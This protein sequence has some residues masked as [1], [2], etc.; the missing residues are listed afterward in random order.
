MDGP[1][2]TAICCAY[3]YARW[4][5]RALDSALAQGVGPETLEVVVVDDGSTDDTAD[6]VRP[7]L[8]SPLI[9]YVWKP[10]GGFAS[11]VSRGFDEAR[12]RYITF[13]DADDEWPLDRLTAQVDVLENSPEIGL[14]YSDMEVIDENSNLI[15]P[16]F[17]QMIQLPTLSGSLLGRL[18]QSNFISG[19]SLMVRAELMSL[20]NPIPSQIRCQDWWI[21]T[22]TASAAEIAWVPGI[23]YRYRQHGQNMNLGQADRSGNARDD[24]EFRRLV[25]DRPE[26]DTVPL[27]ELITASIPLISS[28]IELRSLVSVSAEDRTR[29]A[30]LEQQARAEIFNRRFEAALRTL[31]RAQAANPL[32]ERRG[33]FEELTSLHLLRQEGLGDV[34]TRRVRVLAFASELI[35]DPELLV[36][37]RAAL[38]GNDATVVCQTLSDAELAGIAAL[39]EAAAPD[40]DMVAVTEDVNRLAACCDILLSRLERPGTLRLINRVDSAGALRILVAEQLL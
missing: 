24:F 35:A 27:T 29:S 12:G 8:D 3:N 37:A 38:A 13:L 34:E 22:R 20:F 11:A 5:P 26:S 28:P 14:V 33:V 19:G 18:Y 36:E 2:V 25:L 4:L 39:A 9:R 17:H 15:H 16:S 40:V 31:I 30:E 23:V 10:N 7:Y 32:L 1:L 6:V 21:A